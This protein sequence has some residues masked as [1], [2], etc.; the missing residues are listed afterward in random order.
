VV[1]SA[2]RRGAPGPRPSSASRLR[3]AV[4][5]DALRE[6]DNRATQHRASPIAR[7]TNTWP[8]S[9]AFPTANSQTPTSLSAVADVVAS[10]IAP[11]WIVNLPA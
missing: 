9:F 10:T 7:P 2:S 3:A 1:I 4:V 6:R 5:R 11:E 8:F